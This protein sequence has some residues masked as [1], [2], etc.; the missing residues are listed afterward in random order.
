MPRVVRD[1]QLLVNDDDDHLY[2]YRLSD[3]T[4][5]RIGSSQ[6]DNAAAVVGAAGYSTIALSSSESDAAENLARL[7]SAYQAAN[8]K[9][10]IAGGTVYINDRFLVDDGAHVVTAPGTT[11]KA[12]AGSNTLLIGTA[13]LDESWAT[14]TV[15]WSAGRTA[16]IAWTGHGRQ[17]GDDVV[18]QG[19]TPAASWDNIFTVTSVTDADNIVVDLPFLPSAGPSGAVTAKRCIRNPYVDVSLDYNFANNPGAAYMD[20]MASIFAFVSRGEFHI[21]TQDVYKYGS[22]LAGAADCDLYVESFVPVNSDTVK[23]YGPS[24][25]VRVHAVG[26]AAED[27]ISSQGLEPSAFIGYMPCKGVINGVEFIDSYCRAT[28]AGSGAA[29]IYSDDTYSQRGVKISGG[30]LYAGGSIPAVTI[31]NGSGFTPAS[32][33]LGDI[34]VSPAVIGARGAPALDVQTRAGRVIFAPSVVIPPDAATTRIVRVPNGGVVEM[35]H[36]RGKRFDMAGWPSA[37]GYFAEIAGGGIARELLIE[38]CVFLGGSAL[39]LILAAASSSCNTIT[40][41]NCVATGV[42]GLVRID[43]TPTITPKVIIDGGDYSGVPQGVNARTSMTVVICNSPKFA[44]MNLGVL[45]AELAGTVVEYINDG[46]R[47]LTG[48]SVDFVALTSAVINFKAPNLGVDIGATGVNKAAGNACFNTG[49][50]RGT[51]PQ[52]RPVVCDG[53]SW[54]NATNLSHTF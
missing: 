34:E 25:N 49:T 48:T 10:V 15:T 12:A 21:K 45:R 1:I 43:A 36:I 47:I 51:I 35:L 4:E 31:K 30:E 7:Q 46:S 38:D 19:G 32:A 5:V 24:R 53:T 39:R 22:M 37:T 26:Q 42:D 8:G 23:V 18:L 13:P 44:D 27:T 29:V 2:G 52:N 6:P 14:V 11:I 20:R 33:L 28:T 3:G 16:S 40:L 17:V 9:L 41:R 54:F 50:G